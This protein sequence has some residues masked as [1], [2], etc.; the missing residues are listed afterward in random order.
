MYTIFIL[1]ALYIAPGEKPLL[2]EM[3]QYTKLGLC[4]AKKIES[5][6]KASGKPGR[7]EFACLPVKINI[8]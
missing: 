3:G 2:E 5:Y 1:V 4:N 6:K 8:S 7:Y